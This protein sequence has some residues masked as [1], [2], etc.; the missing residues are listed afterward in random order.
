MATLRPAVSEDRE[1]LRALTTRLGDFP[2][3]TWRTTEEIARADDHL[4]DAALDRPSAETLLLVA[5]GV[6]GVPVGALLATTRSDYF[7]QQP[8]AHIEVVAVVPEAAG[9]GVAKQLMQGAEMWA[10]TRGYTHVTLNVFAT[11]TRAQGMYVHLGYQPE[12]LH[13]IKRF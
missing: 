12:T 4:I 8:H 11:N 9:Q 10:R 6:D 7:T 3:P 5:D 13:F 1:F 2:V